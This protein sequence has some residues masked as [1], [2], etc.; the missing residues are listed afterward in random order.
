MSVNK[1]LVFDSRPTDKVAPANFRLVETPLSKPGAGEILVRNH[2][3]SLDPYMRGRLSDAKSYAKPQEIGAVMGG[4]TVGEVVESNNPHFKPGDFVVGMGGWQQ[5]V[6]TDG[7][8]FQGRRRDERS[9]RRPIS[10]WSECPASP[11]GTD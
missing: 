7:A 11:P 2:Y 3:L 6:V 4:G 5:Y 1:Q 8:G 9:R 10:A